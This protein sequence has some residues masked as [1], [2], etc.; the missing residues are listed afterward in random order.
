MSPL[1]R[2]KIR[3][4]T[5]AVRA[6]PIVTVKEGRDTV[7][8]TH[9]IRGMYPER[10]ER[11]SVPGDVNEQNQSRHTGASHRMVAPRHRPLF[12]ERL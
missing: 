11:V 7:L 9:V 1:Q 3:A 4:K 2:N 5:A 12:R 6:V 8:S 10:S